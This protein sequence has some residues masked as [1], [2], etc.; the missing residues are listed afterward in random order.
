MR[1]KKPNNKDEQKRGAD[2]KPRA[3]EMVKDA[4]E[5]WNALKRLVNGARNITKLEEQL[6]MQD[7]EALKMDPTPPS[8]PPTR[9]AIQPI[10][11]LGT[12]R[13][14]SMFIPCQIDP[15]YTELD[16]AAGFMSLSAG[17]PTRDV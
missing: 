16:I 15:L 7:N 17:T 8:Y 2:K 6:L 10:L 14:G 9:I 12:A 11:P 3:P 13:T 4:S 5:K 1:N